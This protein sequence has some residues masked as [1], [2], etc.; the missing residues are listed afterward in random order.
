MVARHYIIHFRI[1]EAASSVIDAFVMQK[2]ARLDSRNRR[3]INADV[4]A[5]ILHNGAQTII[6]DGNQFT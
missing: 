2:R 4:A 6:A 1:Q 3:A 5:P